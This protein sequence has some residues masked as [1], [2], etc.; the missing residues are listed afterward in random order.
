MTDRDD[1]DNYPARPRWMGWAIAVFMLAAALGVANIGW[2]IMKVSPAEQAAD[3]LLQQ[4]PELAAGKKLVESSDCMRCH[5]WERN[6]VGPAFVSI[7]ERYRSQGDAEAYIARKIREGSVGVWGNVIMPRHPQIDE[8]QSLQ[9]AQ[10]L[11]AVRPAPA[12]AP[13]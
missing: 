3:A 8:A 6:Y 13:Q 12:A 10:W 5:G 7:A 1:E 2:R 9:M 4:H 11:L